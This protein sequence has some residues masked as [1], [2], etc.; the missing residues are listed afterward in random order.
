MV[1]CARSIV[2]GTV[3]FGPA[4]VSS[5]HAA[6]G[7]ASATSAPTPG[8]VRWMKPEGR[9]IQPGRV[10]AVALRM[11]HVRF[12]RA[13]QIGLTTLVTNKR[14]LIRSALVVRPGRSARSVDSLVTEA[15]G[16][17]DRPFAALRWLCPGQ[18]PP[19]KGPINPPLKS[20]LNGLQFN[21][22]SA[23][24]PRNS[25][26]SSSSAR[27]ASSRACWSVSK[28][29]SQTWEVFSASTISRIHRSLESP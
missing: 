23:L 20:P 29:S 27:S 22:C 19:R 2:D 28:C 26:G 9:S 24:R 8:S 6:S 16:P 3:R 12:D 14:T 15:A 7:G 11:Q 5:G 21:G 10:D 18:A 4:T 1:R 17:G 13:D 25:S